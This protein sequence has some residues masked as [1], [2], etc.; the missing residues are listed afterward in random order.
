MSGLNSVDTFDYKY[1][2]KIKF[3]HTTKSR[4]TAPP[5]GK[6]PCLGAHFAKHKIP[7][8]LSKDRQNDFVFTFSYRYVFNGNRKCIRV[9]PLTGTF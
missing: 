8:M 2:L 1:T 9:A 3:T 5:R 6:I 4:S 7:E